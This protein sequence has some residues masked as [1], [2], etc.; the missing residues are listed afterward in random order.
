MTNTEIYLEYEQYLRQSGYALST[1]RTYLNHVRHFYSWAEW[2]NKQIVTI[3]AQSMIAYK[4]QIKQIYSV[5]TIN[6]KLSAI[7]NLYDYLIQVDIRT[8]NPVFNALFISQDKSRPQY[9]TMEQR[10]ML[11][12]YLAT[13]G[14]HIQLAYNIMMYSGLRVSEVCDLELKDIEQREGKI[15]LHIVDKKTNKLRLCPVFDDTTTQ[16]IIDQIQAKM[17]GDKLIDISIRTLQH[18]AKEFQTKNDIKFSV[19]TCRHIFA[20]DRI[21]GGIRLELLKTLMGHKSIT[22]T[23][24]YIYIAEEEIYSLLI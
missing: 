16:Q 22:T 23:L 7:R 2:L 24:L 9:L 17:L 18:Y 5:S 1:I 14:Q 8:E 20:T 19:H 6:N 15:F 3:N 11:M 13:K 4:K 10:G 12:N 21:R